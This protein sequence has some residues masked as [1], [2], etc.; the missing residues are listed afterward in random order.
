MQEM[1]SASL[2]PTTLEPMTL[3]PTTL[4]PTT[5]EPMG[6]EHEGHLYAVGQTIQEPGDSQL[7]VKDFCTRC[8]CIDSDDDPA[9][10]MSVCT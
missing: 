7:Y 6:C 10:C 2:E 9:N 5:L 1:P 8:M 3:E 4:E